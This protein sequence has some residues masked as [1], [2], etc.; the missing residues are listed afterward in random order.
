MNLSKK[1]VTLLI[2]VVASALFVLPASAK[3]Y[4]LKF[5]HVFAPGADQ[6]GPNYFKAI[7]AYLDLKAPGKFKMEEYGSSQMGN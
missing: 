5:G 7:K 4:T 1:F 3:T 6:K 2:L